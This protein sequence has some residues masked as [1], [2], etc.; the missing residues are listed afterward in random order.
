L[1]RERKQSFLGWARWHREHA[2]D[3][4][5]RPD[6]ITVGGWDQMQWDRW[7]GWTHHD[8]RWHTTVIDTSRRL[9]EQT[10]SNI[11]HWIAETRSDSTTGE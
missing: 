10:A 1:G 9:T 6:A 5:Q 11:R 7:S 3:P 2:A 4:Q 8:P